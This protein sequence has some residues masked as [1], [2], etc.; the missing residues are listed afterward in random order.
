MRQEII[1]LTGEQRIGNGTRYIGTVGEHNATELVLTV[2]P[3]LL[4]ASEYVIVLFDVG[5][6]VF[7][8]QRIPVKGGRKKTPPAW[9]SGGAV[10]CYIDCK[11]SGHPRLALQVE[12]WKIGTGGR[13]E[14]V[15]K[16]PLVTGLAFRPSAA[17]CSVIPL[18]ADGTHDHSN[19][20]VLERFGET[21]NVPTF[22]GMPIGTGQAGGAVTVTGRIAVV[23]GFADLDPDAESGSLALVQNADYDLSALELNDYDSD[24]DR[25]R[26]PNKQVSFAQTI[27]YRET[28]YNRALQNHMNSYPLTYREYWSR[29]TFESYCLRR[30]V[31]RKN[32]D[33]TYTDITDGFSVGD[34][35]GGYWYLERDRDF[36]ME[37]EVETTHKD[38][39]LIEDEELCLV[40]VPV[41]QDVRDNIYVREHI[42]CD[43]LFSDGIVA[44]NATTKYVIGALWDGDIRSRSFLDL[45]PGA[46]K[47]AG[48]IYRVPAIYLYA[49]ED[50]DASFEYEVDDDSDRGYHMESLSLH[51]QA[52]WNALFIVGALVYDSED[53]EYEFEGITLDG[54]EPISGA[55]HYSVQTDE[56]GS[57]D[58]HREIDILLFD[59]AFVSREENHPA[60]FFVKTTDWQPINNELLPRVKQADST[61][62]LNGLS[63]RC[64]ELEDRMHEHYNKYLLDNLREESGTLVYN[65]HRMR[66]ISSITFDCRY[67]GY[68][69]Y[70]IDYTDGT[71]GY[72]NIPWQKS[73]DVSQMNFNFSQPAS[74]DTVTAYYSDG[75]EKQFPLYGFDFNLA[76]QGEDSGGMLHQ[77]RT[78]GDRYAYFKFGNFMEYGEWYPLCVDI[79]DLDRNTAKLDYIDMMTG[80]GFETEGLYDRAQRNYTAGYWNADHLRQAVAHGWI[81]ASDFKNMTGMTYEDE[82]YEPYDDPDDEPYDDPDDEPNEEEHNDD[83]D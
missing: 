64:D 18:A 72:F 31:F 46:T 50:L 8:S 51:L 24:R 20:E 45:F 54:A 12:G 13:P 17:G 68:D 25:Y 40:T 36:Y 78:F 10:H 32:D 35:I 48:N 37:A 56:T 7:R 42:E 55:P 9:V 15:M 52:G 77:G 66:D 26:I 21:D 14:C 6:T 41:V 65:G 69:S 79:S 39:S 43:G 3:E 81:T 58:F 33:G 29:A 67:E 2:P 53:R 76:F 70:R 74:W 22:D 11:V 27:E 1:D 57:V 44:P 63:E 59:G 49:F 4:R 34:S 19:L 61:Q 47:I 23:D 38:H 62:I 83:Q 28:V 5:D 16:T 82:N 30:G 60:G 71:V 80:A 73:H 75:T